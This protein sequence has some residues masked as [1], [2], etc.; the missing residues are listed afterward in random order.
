MT[1]GATEDCKDVGHCSDFYGG[2]GCCFC[3]DEHADECATRDLN[4]YECDCSE[5]EQA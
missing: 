4:C 1:L 5:G 2:W 3:D